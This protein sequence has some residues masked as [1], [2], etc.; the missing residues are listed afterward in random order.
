MAVRR[1]Y[2]KKRPRF[3]IAAKNALMNFKETLQIDGLKDV[4]ILVRYDVEG[5]EENAFNQAVHTIFSEPM[6][7]EVFFEN[8]EETGTCF[9]VEYLPGQYDQRADSAAQCVQLLTQSERPLIQTATVYALTGELSEVDKKAIMDY[10]INPVDSRLA[11]T[12]KKTTLAMDVRPPEDVAVVHGFRD[13]SFEE[14]TKMVSGYGFAMKAEDLAFTQEYFKSENR[15]PYI[16]ELRVIDTYWS[17][18]CRHTTFLTRLD[19]VSFGGGTANGRVKKAYQDYLDIRETVYKNREPKDICLMDVAT[20]YPKYAKQQGGLKDLDES[21]EINACSIKQD[22]R[23]G[24]AKQPYLIMF[25]NETHNHPTEIEPF[26]GAAT[27]LGGAIRDPLSGRSYVYQAMRV[28]GA[29]DVTRPVK[30][31]SPGQ[32]AAKEDHD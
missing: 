10:V 11:D 15:D 32:A 8:H 7:D 20:I 27:C 23:V 14:L 12:G 2:V 29:G 25:K 21:E 31:D 28:T 17:D 4:S 6:A 30:E 16:A 19:H 22:I 5:M 3:D 24:D 9:A 13:F 18:H 1:I 26:G